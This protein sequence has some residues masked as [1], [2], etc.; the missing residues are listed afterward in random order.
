[1]V[2]GQSPALAAAAWRWH[3]LGASR[4]HG[5]GRHVVLLRSLLGGVP[6]ADRR[7]GLTAAALLA[8]I[9]RIWAESVPALAAMASRAGVDAAQHDR[10]PSVFHETS[11]RVTDRARPSGNAL[12]LVAPTLR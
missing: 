9:F 3:S 5:D 6:P 10:V 1:M 12:R 7:R 2:P 4:D 11:Q 8:R